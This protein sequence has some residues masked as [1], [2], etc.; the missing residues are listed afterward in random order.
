M[1]LLCTGVI[2]ASSTIH[3]LASSYSVAAHLDAP[4][5][6]G[7]ATI[8]A[9][10]DQIHTT[11]AEADVSGTCPPA[12]YVV[13][14]RGSQTIGTAPCSTGAFQIHV[15]LVYGSNQ[16]QAKVYN[17]TNQEGPASGPI[18]IYRDPVPETPASLPAPAQQ[19]IPLTLSVTA[20][21]RNTVTQSNTPKTSTS[22][23]VSGFA[24]PFSDVII[25][26]HSDVQTCKTKADGS[27]WWSCT[28]AKTLPGGSHHVDVE[29]WT[30]EGVRLTFPTFQIVVLGDLPSLIPQR[31][32]V[33]AIL[34]DYQYQ[35]HTVGKAFS[36]NLSLEGGKAPYKVTIN[37][38]D[39]SDS[40]L[41]RT[42]GSQFTIKHAFPEK[43]TYT[44][45]VSVVDGSGVQTV[46]QLFAIVKGQNG[47]A[48]TTATP[49]P[50]IS[51]LAM[52]QRYLWVVWPAYIAV[53]LMAFS[54]WL[55][56]KEMYLR[57]SRRQMAH[58]GPV[59]NG[60]KRRRV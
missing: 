34:I 53:V 45:F 31:S 40:T 51:M 6:S 25:T 41:I 2:I 43:Q 29:A 21:D 55:G 26:F 19:E 58:H 24:P 46:L 10:S 44:V 47:T 7:P 5:P 50:V 49:G 1:V 32:T 14:F 3:G 52:V 33:P 36:W 20:I 38:G 4:L 57:F 8:A 30:P 22:P 23:T 54:Y 12:S 59:G 60:N 27:G 37:W 35:T 17:V 16:L 39:G 56:E 9:P 11:S 28:L 15:S 48:A 18:T 42:D 13:L